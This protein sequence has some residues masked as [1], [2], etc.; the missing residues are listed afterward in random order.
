MCI[1]TLH[2]PLDLL[3]DTH[4]PRVFTLPGPDEATIAVTLLRADRERAITP[5]QAQ[6]ACLARL[7]YQPRGEIQRDFEALAAG[8]LPEDSDPGE[9]VANTIPRLTDSG[10][11][12]SPSDAPYHVMPER[13][14]D[15]IVTVRSALAEAAQRTVGLL[16]WRTAQEDGYFNAIRTRGAVWSLDGETWFHLPGA[17]QITPTITS[18][19]VLSDAVQADVQHA[20]DGAQAE[21]LAQRLWL[22]AW[23]LR[24]ASPRSALLIGMGALDAGVRSRIVHA[25][26]AAGWLV[27]AMPSPPTIKMLRQYLP[28][29][30]A[31]DG[32]AWPTPLDP[33][34]DLL[35]EAQDVREAIALQGRLEIDQAWLKAVLRAV[36]TLLWRVDA[37]NGAAWATTADVGR[38]R[39]EAIVQRIMEDIARDPAADD[40]AS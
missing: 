32:T 8:R 31:S 19:A 39:T 28:Q 4:A 16:R 25:V 35:S 15:E 22:E 38:Q 36:R 40:P 20:L 6:L 26:P 12:E 14:R 1:Q 17:H 5:W 10:Q 2:E 27:S 24:T 23:Q 30:P 33:D 9:Q 7:D 37:A 11:L 29:L 18:P 21:P 3:L 13:L 34:L